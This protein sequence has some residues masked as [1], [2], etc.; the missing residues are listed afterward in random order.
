MNQAKFVPEK[1]ILERKWSI[2]NNKNFYL[3]LKSFLQR[4]LWTVNIWQIMKRSV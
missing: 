2:W 3:L 4:K 1:E